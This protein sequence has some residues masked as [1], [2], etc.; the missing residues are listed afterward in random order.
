MAHKF[1]ITSR[2]K[3]NSEERRK[4]L[5][6]RET[7]IRLGY[8]KGDTMADIGCGTGLFHPTGSRTFLEKHKNICN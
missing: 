2:K 1:D 6:P 4:L 8:K 3:L 7:L 5:A